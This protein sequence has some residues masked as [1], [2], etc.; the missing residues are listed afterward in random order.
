MART[1]VVKLHYQT[2]KV[3]CKRSFGGE[4]AISPETPHCWARQAEI[5]E[6]LHEGLNSEERE[7]LRRLRREN[8][9][10]CEEREILKKSAAFFAPL[11]RGHH[12]RTHLSG[13]PPFSLRD[14]RLEPHV[15]R[16][17]DP[18]RPESGA[19]SRCARNGAPDKKAL[20]GPHRLLRPR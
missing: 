7:E 18:R 17:V 4:F 13:L 6:A 1:A 16:L 12:L 15:G 19:G 9:R 8:A 11:G 14:R 5:D 10:L 3:A 2:P 20:A